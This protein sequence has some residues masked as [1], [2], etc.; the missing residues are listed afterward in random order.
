MVLRRLPRRSSPPGR[1]QGA[2]LPRHRTSSAGASTTARCTCRTRS[3]R[4]SGAHLGHGG[5]VGD[6]CITCPFHGWSYDA[7]GTNVEIPYSERVNRKARLRTF[8]VVERNGLSM[9]WYHPDESVAPMW[10][11]PEFPE[12]GDASRVVA[13]C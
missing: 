13:P 8:P 3:A 10:E 6:G 11:V 7:E 12:F 5:T 1:A 9:I 4:T 2:V